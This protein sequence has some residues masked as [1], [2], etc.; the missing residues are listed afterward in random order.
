MVATDGSEKDMVSGFAVVVE[1]IDEVIHGGVTGEDQSPFKAEAYAMVVLLEALSGLP[2]PS[3]PTHCTVAV[4]C[5]AA[6][7]VFFG[8][9]SELPG[10]A[11]RLGVRA[12]LHTHWLLNMGACELHAS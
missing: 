11:R 1:G 5:Q 3:T 10:L 8:K 6:L 7:A 2:A 9:G 4:D 12:G